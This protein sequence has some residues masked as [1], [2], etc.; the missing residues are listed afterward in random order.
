MVVEVWRCS[1]VVDGGGRRL[2]DAL[3]AASRARAKW[4]SF[5]RKIYPIVT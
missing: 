2:G 4:Q 3:W 5:Q 1:L